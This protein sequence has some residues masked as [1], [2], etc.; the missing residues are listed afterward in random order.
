MTAQAIAERPLTTGRH[1]AI[2]ILR[3]PA[4]AVAAER[5]FRVAP[6]RGHTVR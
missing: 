5:K 3:E 1:Q 4:K 2:S 6:A